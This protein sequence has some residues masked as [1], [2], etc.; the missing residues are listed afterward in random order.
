V[1]A[2]SSPNLRRHH[3]QRRVDV[4]FWPLATFRCRAMTCRFRGKADSRVWFSRESSRSCTASTDAIPRVDAYRMPFHSPHHLCQ[5]ASQHTRLRPEPCFRRLRR[6]SCTDSR[7]NAPAPLDFRAPLAPESCARAL[8][9]EIGDESLRIANRGLG[10][11]YRLLSF[12]KSEL[13]LTAALLNDTLTDVKHGG[14]LILIS[15]I[16]RS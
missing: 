13:L 11:T 9:F 4:A 2:R 14:H 3:R 12:G 8:D 6:C 7:R 1:A 16:N 5:W 10:S 15:S